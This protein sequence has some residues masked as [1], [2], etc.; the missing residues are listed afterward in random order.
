M[1]FAKVAA[2][3]ISTK[4][5]KLNKDLKTL[6]HCKNSHCFR[7]N[8][9]MFLFCSN[10]SILC[11]SC[12]VANRDQNYKAEEKLK[13]IRYTAKYNLSVLHQNYKDCEDLSIDRSEG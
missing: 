2:L 9:N 7:R 10:N 13:N 11:K 1:Y 5:T 12:C 6:G 8:K 3:Q 4:A